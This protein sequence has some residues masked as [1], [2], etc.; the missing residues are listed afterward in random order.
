MNNRVGHSIGFE[1]RFIVSNWPGIGFFPLSRSKFLL[2]RSS[3]WFVNVGGM[4]RSRED[5][6]LATRAIW[7]S[8]ANLSN[9]GRVECDGVKNAAKILEEGFREKD[10]PQ[11]P[12]RSRRK[13]GRK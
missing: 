7:E 4:G 12:V 5:D 3:T 2:E 6:K 13:G 10:A 11:L 9:I 1:D 8:N